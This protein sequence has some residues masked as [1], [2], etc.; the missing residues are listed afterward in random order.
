MSDTPKK[1]KCRP[2]LKT[3]RFK[4]KLT[5]NKYYQYARVVR[6]DRRWLLMIAVARFPLGRALGT[7]FYSRRT[8]FDRETNQTILSKTDEANS[9]SDRF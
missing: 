6:G 4:I 9:I 3:L 7:L 5:L 2:L 1:I 8:G